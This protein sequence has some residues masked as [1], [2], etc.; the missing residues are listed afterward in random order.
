[1]GFEHLE[2]R[3]NVLLEQNKKRRKGQKHRKSLRLT[4]AGSLTHNV[5]TLTVTL[6]LQGVEWLAS[7]PGV[8]GD[9]CEALHVE[10]LLHG[11]AAAAIADDVIPA[12]S[13]AT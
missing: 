7:Q 6:L 13:A 10:H 3:S 11:D 12:A 5:T 4:L 2:Q 8:A 1:M 9:A